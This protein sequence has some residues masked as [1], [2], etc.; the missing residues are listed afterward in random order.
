MFLP[1]MAQMSTD[2][3][4]VAALVVVAGALAYLG[5]SAWKKRTKPGCGGGCGCA[6]DESKA[7]LK[8]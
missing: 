3:Q 7:G 6:A 2:F 5:W 1:P 8:R 4:T